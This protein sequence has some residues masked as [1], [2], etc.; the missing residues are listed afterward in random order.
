MPVHSAAIL[1]YRW[2]DGHVLEV[3]VAHMGGPFWAKKDAGAWSLV[4]GEF[5]PAGENAE[6]AARREF[7]EEV[8]VVFAGDLQELCEFRQPSGKVI[9]VFVGGGPDGLAFVGSNEF[10]IEWPPRCGQ[11][12][13]FPEI[14]RAQW[15]ELGVAR[16][17]LV[18]GQRPILDALLERVSAEADTGSCR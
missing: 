12:R 10:E 15:L 1:P 2:R 13:S 9:T 14:D 16:Q 5:D 18:K 7:A 3:F 11:R 8:G 4:K 17:K 6:A